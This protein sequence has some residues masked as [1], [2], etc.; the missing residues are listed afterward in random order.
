M[1]IKLDKS[2][3]AFE[4]AKNYH[5][6]GVLA[7]RRPYNYVE[8]EYPIFFESGTGGKVTD[9]D[10]NEYIDM[11]CSYGPIIIGHREKEID[12]S[13]INQIRSKGFNFSLTQP[14]H[15]TLAKKITELIP[16]AEQT[17]FVKTGSDATSAAIRAARA[18]TGKNKILRCG[19]HGWHDWCSEV[20]GGIPK[21]VYSDVLDFN[22][23]DYN[24][25]KE[26]IENNENEIAAVIL[27]PIHT[28]L[29]NKVEMPNDNF[30][31]KVRDITSKKNIVLIF[32]E[33]R[34]GF[35]VDLGGAQKK[36]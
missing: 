30:L 13:V 20:K 28:P 6:G 14:I 34:T 10:G 27:W 29:G 11:L 3:A 9:I 26:I 16:C 25:L 24:S 8:N 2:F 19:Y 7:I 5:P 33:I 23:N 12:D 32:D 1:T 4:D 31:E 17:I 22:Y 15:N 36:I 18:Y 35:R 21:S